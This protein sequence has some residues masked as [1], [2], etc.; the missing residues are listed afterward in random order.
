MTRRALMSKYARSRGVPVA[1]AV[2]A[3]TALAIF[4]LDTLTPQDI[5]FAMLYVA[6]VMMASSFCQPR[7]VWLVFL[8]C[9]GLTVL[10][11]VLSPPAITPQIVAI[12][13]KA[14]RHHGD[15]A[16]S[17]P[18]RALSVDGGSGARVGQAPRP[19]A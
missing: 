10:G 11:H 15:G 6:V 19:D 8:G 16:H 4:I 5:T 7:E 13:N 17:L 12:F 14:P 1:T 9:V 2:T 18:L 3:V